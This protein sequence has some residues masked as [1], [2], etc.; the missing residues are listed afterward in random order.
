[1]SETQDTSSVR[2]RIFFYI[3]FAILTILSIIL[4]EPFISVIV[5]SLISVLMLQ[6]VYRFF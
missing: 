1:M 6:P 4:L 2:F 5:V 3:L